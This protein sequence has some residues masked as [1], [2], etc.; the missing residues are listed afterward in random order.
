MPCERL[1]RSLL[2]GSRQMHRPRVDARVGML[3]AV[4]L[5]DVAR[6]AVLTQLGLDHALAARRVAVPLLPPPAGEGR[7]VEVAEC[8]Q[9]VAGRRDDL[10][11]GGRP[12]QAPLDFPARPWPGAEEGHRD[13]E[14]TLGVGRRARLS[15]PIPRRAW[16]PPRRTYSAS[17]MPS[18]PTSM[19]ATLPRISSSIFCGDLG[20]LLQEVPGVLTTLAEADVAVVEPRP[21]LAEDA[22]GDADVEQA[23][24]DADALVVHDVEL[25]DAERAGDLVL[26]DLDPGA[27]ADRI[28][29]G[30]ERLDAADV[31]PDAG[32]ELQR[33]TAGRRLRV[34]EHDA[35]LLAQL[36]RE[37]QRRL[38]AVDG[39]GQLAQRLAHEPCLEADEGVAHVA[40]DLGP[41]HERRDRVDDDDVDA[42]GADQ[43]LGD[44]EGLL[45]ACRAG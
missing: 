26:H 19:L 28:G 1:G 45:A 42:A 18:G 7:V 43:G 30:L 13:L 29:P 20:V 6:H 15:A 12:P 9:P 33:A 41:R 16:P 32:V 17:L 39:A 34:A 5:D 24:F 38:A 10:V 35:D 27:G 31:E 23:A 22:G 44:L 2:L 37:D 21:G 40:L 8:H 14:R 4:G 25:G 11:R 3:A 36:V